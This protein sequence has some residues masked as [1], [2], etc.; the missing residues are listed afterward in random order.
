[1][2]GRHRYLSQRGDVIVDE[3]QRVREAVT[4]VEAAEDS[5]EMLE[6]PSKTE[7]A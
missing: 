4:E 2:N 7:M 6:L 1:M 5:I 3:G